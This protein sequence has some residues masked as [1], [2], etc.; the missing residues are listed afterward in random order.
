MS[1][2]TVVNS[3]LLMAIAV[4]CVVMNGCTMGFDQSMMNNMNI[5]T[6]YL[7]YFN[8]D[9]SYEVLFSAAINIGSV[10]GGFF[11]SQL[12]DLKYVGRKGGILISS[13]ITFLGVALQ[14]AARNRAMFIMG[15]I[16]I[17]IAVTVNAVAAPTY[18]AELAHPKDRGFLT[19]IYMASWYFAAIIVTGISLGT[20]NLD[21][22][23][24][25]RAI[26]LCQITPSVLVIP[27]LYFIR[28]VQDF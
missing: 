1:E 22:T 28:R 5:I 11:S 24:S 6:Q 8:L 9:A 3:R 15:R 20:Y 7:D 23:W 12:I 16:I 14:T 13:L 18:V 25:W 17:G 19:G 2:E 27:V 4:Y 21:S 10:I 26:S